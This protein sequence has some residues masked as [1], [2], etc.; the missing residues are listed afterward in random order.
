MNY[1]ILIF[2]IILSS[3]S[4]PKSVFICGDHV[5]VN[6]KEANKYFEENLSIQVKII[7][8]KDE[9]N[10]PDLIELNMIDNDT[11]KRKI[12]AKKKESTDKTLKILSKEEVK[13]IKKEIKR[14]SQKKKVKDKSLNKNGELKATSSIHS[15]V[16]KK[17]KIDKSNNNIKNLKKVHKDVIDICTILDK[18]NIEEISKYLIKEG[19]NKKFPN[20]TLRE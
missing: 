19:K 6:K 12:Y 4:K 15:N 5:C 14:K 7:N 17:I 1:L 10:K 8:K 18:C 9:F 3:C 16:A 13:N 2:I 20:I 11:N